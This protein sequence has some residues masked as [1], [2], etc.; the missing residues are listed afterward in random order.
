MILCDKTVIFKNYTIFAGIMR[1]T[2]KLRIKELMIQKGIKPTPHRLVKLGIPFSTAKQMLAGT[3][4]SIQYVHLV[5]LCIMFNCTPKEIMDV[6][7]PENDGVQPA[8]PIWEWVGNKLPTP[9][10]DFHAF[11]P[12]QIQKL[13]DVMKEIR[14]NG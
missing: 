13:S 3:T 7:I 2:I 1:A 6:Q 10:Q 9:L 12:A 14:A 11:S 5:Q 8:H 4:K